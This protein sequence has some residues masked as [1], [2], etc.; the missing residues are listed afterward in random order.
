M[1]LPSRTSTRGSRTGRTRRLLAAT[2]AALVVAA[3]IVATPAAATGVTAT[4]TVGTASPVATRASEPGV[5]ESDWTL[6]DSEEFT[7][8]DRSR[9]HV[10]DTRSNGDASHVFRPWRAKVRQGALQ[11]SSGMGKNGVWS[12]GTV[13]GWGWQA[14]TL[15][16]GRVDMRVRT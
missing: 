15:R 11:L 4:G 13:G 1:S 2:S 3:G 9:W 8:F 5:A 16:E 7:S 12:S 10:Y 14:A 6:L